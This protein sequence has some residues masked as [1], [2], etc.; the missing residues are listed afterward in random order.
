MQIKE[1][2]KEKIT[3]AD[4]EQLHKILNITKT[5]KTQILN[6][7]GRMTQKEILRLAFL[8]EAAPSELINLGCGRDTITISEAVEMET[9]I[10]Q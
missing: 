8:L 10:H 7:P 2:I 1:F 5:R 3:V 9:L 6:N 4:Y